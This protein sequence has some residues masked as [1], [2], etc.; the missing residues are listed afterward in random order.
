M[1]HVGGVKERYSEPLVDSHKTYH[2]DN[3]G[4]SLFHAAEFACGC[5]TMMFVVMVY[6]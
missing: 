3:R 2:S 6:F 5:E 4:I 1:Q